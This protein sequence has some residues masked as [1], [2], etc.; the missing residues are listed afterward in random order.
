MM[1]IMITVI[2]AT[3]DEL[4]QKLPPMSVLLLFINTEDS[5]REANY[6]RRFRN[7]PLKQKV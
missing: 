6:T 2:M 5:Y 4:R 3:H 1:D 7:S